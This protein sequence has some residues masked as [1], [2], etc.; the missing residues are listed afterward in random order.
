[1]TLSGDDTGSKPIKGP[2]NKKQ[3]WSS[4]VLFFL[5]GTYGV[6]GACFLVTEMP[7]DSSTHGVT[8]GHYLWLPLPRLSEPLSH[9]WAES[10][11]PEHSASLKTHTGI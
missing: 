1:M 6:F 7:R 5:L 9:R 3:S 4:A 2:L 8:L 10:Q 11:T